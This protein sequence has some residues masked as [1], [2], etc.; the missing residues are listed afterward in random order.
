MVSRDEKARRKQ[1]VADLRRREREGRRD[2]L[3]VDRDG[4]LAL[5]QHLETR[6]PTAGCDDTFR[7]TAAWARTQGVED[8]ELEDSLARASSVFC[9]CEVLLNV[10][11]DDFFE[12]TGERPS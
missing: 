9:D 2:L 5:L 4:L 12:S 8:T 6:L 1:V 3:P 7:L 11:A 10:D